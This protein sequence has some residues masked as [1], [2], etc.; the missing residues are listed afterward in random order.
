MDW[1][2]HVGFVPESIEIPIDGATIGFTTIVIGALVTFTG[3]AQPALEVKVQ[4]I[5][6]PL[7]NVDEVNVARLTPAFAPLICH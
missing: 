1:P 6:S 7:F 2:A 3:L 4:V 5:T